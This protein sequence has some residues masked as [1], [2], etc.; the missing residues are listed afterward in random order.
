[1]DENT[2][3]V[4]SRNEEVNPDSTCPKCGQALTIGEWPFCPHG[5]AHFQVIGDDIPGG[6]VIKHGICNPDGSPRTYYSYSSMRKEAKERGL[7]QGGDTP[8]ASNQHLERLHAEREAR[9]R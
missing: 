5:R 1:M 6:V 7:F 4:Q 2:N 8:K 9:G 3:P